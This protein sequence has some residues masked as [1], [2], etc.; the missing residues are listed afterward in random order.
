MARTESD[1]ERIARLHVPAEDEVPED[2]KELWTKPL[3]KLGFVP[4]VLR[5]FALRP[6]HLLAWW[7]YYDELLRG[8]SGLTKAQREMIA[9][10]VSATNRCHYCV[11]SHTA[12]LRK[13]TED[14]VLV[15][16]LATGYKYAPLDERDRAMLDF[17]VKLTEASDRCGDEDVEALREAGWSDEEIMDIAEVAAMFNFT[18]RLAS[19]LGWT[20]NREYFSLGR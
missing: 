2:V 18:N 20:P 1:T 4:N 14:P 5:A 19:G 10:V 15:D 9:V 11:V 6:A 13:L 12:A 16:Q 7:A 8:D 3:E 17:A